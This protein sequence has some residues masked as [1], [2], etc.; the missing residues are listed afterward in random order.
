VRRGGR[1]V[2]LVS[3]RPE[4]VVAP[5]LL[6]ATAPVPTVGYC[7]TGDEA[8]GCGDCLAAITIQPK[9]VVRY[10]LETVAPKGG[11]FVARVVPVE[12]A[13][14]SVRVKVAAGGKALL[15]RDVAPGAEALAVKVDVPA[16]GTL[17]FEVDYGPQLLFPSGVRFEDPML[18]LAPGA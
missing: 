5:G 14:S 16:G 15:E 7:R 12:G 6:G 10:K 18:I 13:K 4:S 3:V 9:T 2:D 17:D 8:Q 1:A 11:Q